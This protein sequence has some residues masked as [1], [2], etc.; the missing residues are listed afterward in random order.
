MERGDTGKR[1]GRGRGGAPERLLP[2][3]DIMFFRLPHL[4]QAAQGLV[5]IQIRML[6]S[7]GFAYLPLRAIIGPTEYL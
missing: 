6:L 1:G 4:A 2:N 5:F 7:L 3:N